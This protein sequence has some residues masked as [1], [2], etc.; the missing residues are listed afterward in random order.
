LGGKGGPGGPGAGGNGGPSYALVYK[1]EFPTANNSTL[2][3]ATGGTGGPGG[4]VLNMTG[5]EGSTGDSNLK[6]LVP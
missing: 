4:T 5:R 2:K 6:F 1:G 3:A